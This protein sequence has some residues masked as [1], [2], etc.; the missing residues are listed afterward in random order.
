[1]RKDLIHRANTIILGKDYLKYSE[2]PSQS[3]ADTLEYVLYHHLAMFQLMRGK[4]ESLDEA[5]FNSETL[6]RF[7]LEGDLR[8]GRIVIPKELTLDADFY[9]SIDLT[10]VETGETLPPEAFRTPVSVSLGTKVQKGDE[11][12]FTSDGVFRAEYFFARIGNGAGDNGSKFTPLKV[13]F[14]PVTNEKLLEWLIETPRMP[15]SVLW[16]LKNKVG[17]LENE[18]T[19]QMNFIADQK[20]RIVGILGRIHRHDVPAT[21]K[22]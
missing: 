1:M 17:T 22:K 6:S 12:I 19:R 11:L 18:V 5:F 3:F 9:M 4:Y 13:Y 10:D 16:R 7:R 2:I 14:T 21:K 15:L 8:K 20:E